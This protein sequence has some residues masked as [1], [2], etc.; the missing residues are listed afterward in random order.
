MRLP[1]IMEKD[2]PVDYIR[3]KRREDP[4]ESETEGTIEVTQLKKHFNIWAAIGINY[5]ISVTP[6]TVGCNLA[7]AIGVGG[8][9]MF[10]YRFVFTGFFQL[11][12]CLALAEMSSAMP[13]SSGQ[14]SA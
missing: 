11:I 10:F 6:L 2:N 5:S 7:L 4:P 3:L 9:P 1:T 8:S 13:S 12:L 14:Y